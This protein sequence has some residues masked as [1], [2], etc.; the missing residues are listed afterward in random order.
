MKAIAYGGEKTVAPGQDPYN[1]R[2][3]FKF[4]RL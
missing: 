2:V 3:E 1:E 4:K